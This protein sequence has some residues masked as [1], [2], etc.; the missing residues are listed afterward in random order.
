MV[1]FFIFEHTVFR[2][3]AFK[4]TKQCVK[5]YIYCICI[6][7]K[8]IN[9]KLGKSHVTN[10]PHWITNKLPR[11]LV[12]PF[13]YLHSTG[14][15]GTQTLPEVDVDIANAPG[16]Y[17]KWLFVIFKKQENTFKNLGELEEWDQKF[18]EICMHYIIAYIS[19]WRGKEIFNE[20]SSSSGTFHFPMSFSSK[21]R[22]GF[23]PEYPRLSAENPWPA[24]PKHP[25][26]GLSFCKIFAQDWSW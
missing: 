22:G 10:W 7:R 21:R 14:A 15:I 17:C 1:L 13:L 8:S 23:L 19:F 12:C 20:N 11:Q 4:S 25:P 18:F 3:E 2:D 24:A 5:I 9:S 16:A 6:R 26:N